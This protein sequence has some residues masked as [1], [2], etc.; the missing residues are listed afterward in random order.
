MEPEDDSMVQTCSFPMSH[1]HVSDQS[2]SLCSTGRFLV[3]SN[4]PLTFHYIGCLIG[5]LIMVLL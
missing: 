2:L 5:I 3:S 4:D 1:G